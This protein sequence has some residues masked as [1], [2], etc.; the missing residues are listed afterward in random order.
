MKGYNFL[1]LLKGHNFFFFL[2]LVKGH[3]FFVKS[4]S[5]YLLAEIASRKFWP[6]GLDRDF[7]AFLQT[8]G[9]RSNTIGGVL[10]ALPI[11]GRSTQRAVS[12]V[13]QTSKSHTTELSTSD[14]AMAARTN[15]KKI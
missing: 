1:L 15:R 14:N 12:M 2:L 5:L 8:E 11:P 9:V 4:Y 10:L 6:P 3:N 7:E 13:T